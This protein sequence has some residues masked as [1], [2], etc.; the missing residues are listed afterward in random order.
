M[1]VF[2]DDDPLALE[3]V[4]LA[5]EPAGWVVHTCTTAAVAMTLIRTHDPSVVLV[6][7]LMPETDGFEVVDILRSDPQTASLPVVVLTAKTLTPRDRALL[8]GRIDFV[9]SKSTVDL[10][11]LAERLAQITSAPVSARGKEAG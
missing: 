2:V 6:D 4:R 10:G 3:L 7:L 9:M 1:A 8:D 5:L 11:L